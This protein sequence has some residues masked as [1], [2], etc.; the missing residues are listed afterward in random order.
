MMT[1]E[2]LQFRFNEFSHLLKE[3]DK[4][5]CI[6]WAKAI[7]DQQQMS[8]VELYSQI[9]V[10]SLNRIASNNI[11]Q[12][13]PIWEEHVKSGII[14]CIIEI[15]YP[16]LLEQIAQ[17]QVS[18]H[19]HKAVIL[20]LE[21]EYHELGARI[22]ADYLT[23][24]DFEVIFVGANTPK[25]EIYSAISQLHPKLLVISVTNYFHLVKLQTFIEEIRVKGPHM[26]LIAVGGY[27]I[28]H[29][30]QAHQLINPDFFVNSFEDF[31]KIKEAIL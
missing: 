4:P 27:A 14:R 6:D 25:S 31:Q 20:C 2:Q 15:A 17:T 18:P 13:I 30:P 19:L 9:L 8:L 23:L 10:P 26:P 28:D 12:E 7:L 21:E 16:Y 11:H 3:L 24:L 22:A 1:Q 5:A 29:T